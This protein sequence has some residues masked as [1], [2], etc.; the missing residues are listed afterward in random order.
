MA[1]FDHVSDI[2]DATRKAPDDV[3]SPTLATMEKVLGGYDSILD[4][5][6]GTGRC[7]KPLSDRG[8]PIVG[9]DISTSMMAKAREKGLED[10]VRGDAHHLP[11][12]DRSFDAVIFVLLLH[13]V[14]DWV[15]VLH[16]IEEK[17]DRK[18]TRLNSSHDQISYAVFCLKK[19]RKYHFS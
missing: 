4:V 12:L 13:L 19:K 16:E 18:S 1:D 15:T 8:L 7:A 6:T 17:Q 2:Y 9:V 14:Q 11:F 3:M 10:L 5:G